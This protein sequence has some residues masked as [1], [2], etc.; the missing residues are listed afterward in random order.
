MPESATHPVSLDLPLRGLRGRSSARLVYGSTML[1]MLLAFL[2]FSVD[3]WM[4]TR[5]AFERELDHLNRTMVQTTEAV[6]ANQESMLR[7]LGRRLEEVGALQDP[8]RGRA[9]VE[10]MMAINTWMA[11]F[12]LARPDGQ[13]LLVSRVPP[14]RPLPNLM[15]REASRSGFE[16]AL[17]RQDMVIGRTYF[18]PLLERWLIPVRLALRD[19]KGEVSLVMTA[20]INIDAATAMWNIID[21][22]ESIRA[23]MQVILVRDDG[24]VQLQLPARIAQREHLYAEPLGTGPMPL[25][26]SDIDDPWMR[27]HLARVRPLERLPMAS[28]ATVS[29][30]EVRAAYFEAMFVPLTLFIAAQ[31]LGWLF[32]RYLRRNQEAYERHLIHH[33]THDALTTLPNRLLLADRVNQDIA[34]A[35]RNRT[36]VAVMYVDLDQFKRVNDSFG[37]KVGDR[38]LR[39]CAERLRQ[40]LRDGDTVGRLSGDEFLVVFPD[41]AEADRARG[42]AARIIEEFHRPF[43][44]A[45]RELFSTAS[46][47]VALYPHD[48]DDAD[49]LLQNA[50]A[51][52]Y[53]AKADG[54][55]SFCFFEPRHNAATARRILVESA[56]RSAIDKQEL[57]VVYQPKAGGESLK[58]EGAEALLRWESGTLGT[59]SPAEFIPVA[60]ETGLIDQLGWFVIDKVLE[61]LHW[62][63]ECMIDFG[64]AVNV[65]VRQF[66]DPEFIPQLLT[67]L[68][69]SG[70]PPGLL[71]LEVTESIMA[72]SIP[73]L[74]KLRDAGLRLAI[75]DFGTGFSCLSYLKRLPVTTLKLDREFV[76]DLEVD[77]ADKALVTAMLAIAREFDLETVAEGV[78]TDGQLAFLRAQRC[79]QIQGYLLGEPMPIDALLAELRTGRHR[80]RAL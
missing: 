69:A 78:E 31:T 17:S 5:S 18:F 32:Y 54:R 27:G 4:Q 16:D 73:Q 61:D 47:G 80:V 39:A 23:G 29:P 45:G 22:R 40:I 26:P 10:Q 56:L 15:A 64:V 75:D 7:L 3:T 51:A 67:R 57:R 30:Q 37:H 42:L 33:A 1:V 43:N 21:F 52:L 65:S 12:G 62:M 11:G 20:G 44:L 41:L 14:G 59:V 63:R 25:E 24:F 58:W 13:L 55:N 74:G 6:F 60:E 49:Q 70:V 35:R 36:H 76:R 50:D 2:L 72:E 8:E 68:R 34:R 77:S 38:L 19:A 66:R 71:E 48:G 79:S 28:V 46:I 9:L 53:Q